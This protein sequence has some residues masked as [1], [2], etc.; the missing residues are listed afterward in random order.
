MIVVQQD[1]EQAHLGPRGLTLFIE[2][3]TDLGVGRPL[4]LVERIDLDHAECLDVLRLAVFE[5]GKLVLL[6]VEYRIAFVVADD[7]IDAYEIDRALEGG[8][9]LRVLL[10][11]RRLLFGWRL[12]LR[13]LL[14]RR[15]ILR[16]RILRLLAVKAAR[17]KCDQDRGYK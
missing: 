7:Y 15:R 1:D 9:L 4:D 6:Q 12:L 14:F 17:E 10:R 8:L 5:D 11:R 16:R 13:R 3:C 2:R